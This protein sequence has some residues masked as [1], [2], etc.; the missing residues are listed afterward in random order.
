M[1]LH[2]T[3]SIVSL[4]LLYG[5]HRGWP[6]GWLRRSIE[7]SQQAA[8]LARLLEH[9]QPISAHAPRGLLV[10]IARD[11][12]IDPGIATHWNEPILRH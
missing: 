10:R 2:E 1:L 9:G 5:P 6:Q 11:L 7:C 8:D 4:D 12:M 3:D